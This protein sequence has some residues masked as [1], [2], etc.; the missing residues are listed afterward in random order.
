[1][2]ENVAKHPYKVL[3]LVLDL[4]EELLCLVDNGLG[5][6]RVSQPDGQCVTADIVCNHRR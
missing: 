1:M 2:L 5:F 6:Q 4:G 3:H